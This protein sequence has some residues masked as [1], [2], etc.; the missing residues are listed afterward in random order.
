MKSL[1]LQYNHYLLLA[2]PLLFLF[3][4]FSNREAIDIQMHDT[5]IVAHLQSI[6]IL[7]SILLTTLAALYFLAEH[8]DLKLNPKWSQFHVVFTVLCL[9]IFFLYISFI[10]D[11]YVST[12]P[13]SAFFATNNPN[14]TKITLMTLP[15]LLFGLCQIVFLG[16][17]IFR[18]FKK[19][20]S[21]N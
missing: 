8:F 10:S 11:T 3:S 6:A 7:F 9:L 14:N 15:I 19:I 2:I 20:S 16:H 5:Y 17:L 21:P 4:L 1:N 12:N 13:V 18:I